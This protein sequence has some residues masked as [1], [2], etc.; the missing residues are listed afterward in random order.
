M[1]RK[2][3]KDLTSVETEH[4]KACLVDLGEGWN[5]DYNEDDPEDEPLFRFDY[6]SRESVNDE[7][8]IPNDSS[9]C[10]QTNANIGHQLRKEFLEYLIE[11][12][13]DLSWDANIKH[14]CESLS[15]TR[16]EHIN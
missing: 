6:Y 4:W 12:V 13:E 10:T 2:F 16:I 9:Y 14:L 1:S 11:Q 15:W 8:Q 3:N 5:G 7:W